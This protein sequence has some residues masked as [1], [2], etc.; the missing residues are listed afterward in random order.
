[1]WFRHEAALT[2]AIADEF[3]L[4]EPSDEIRF[5]VRFA[6]QIQLSASRDA[7]PEPAVTAGFRLL[8]EGWARYEAQPAGKPAAKEGN[9]VLRLGRRRAIHHDEGVGLQPGHRQD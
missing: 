6:L 1:M 2:A 5:Y 8:D 9:H 7:D 4:A 3:K